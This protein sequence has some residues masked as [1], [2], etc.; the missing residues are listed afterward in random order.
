MRLAGQLLTLLMTAMAFASRGVAALSLALN[1]AFLAAVGFG[2]VITPAQLSGS[3]QKL[4]A[5]TLQSANFT[6][7]FLVLL[8]LALAGGL[9]ARSQTLEPDNPRRAPAHRAGELMFACAYSLLIALSLAFTLRV[10]NLETLPAGQG[11]IFEG[12]RFTA[13]L[14]PSLAVLTGLAAA[15]YF[16]A[17]VFFI[18]LSLNPWRHL[19][20]PTVEPQSSAASPASPTVTASNGTFPPPDPPVTAVVVPAQPTAPV[21]PPRP[22]RGKRRKH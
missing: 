6:I 17:G 7:T 20:L 18:E 2:T 15:W 9:T 13:T 4:L 19:L 8:L 12:L 14:N 1:L 16:L 21:V 10:V 5:D 11:V 22:R 3:M